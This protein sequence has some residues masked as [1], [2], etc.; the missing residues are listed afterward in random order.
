MSGIPRLIVDRQSPTLKETL[1]Q[2]VSDA[3]KDDIMAPVTVVGPTRYANL[4]LRHE[5]GRSGFIN[6]R[7]VVLPVLSE[8]LGAA[9]LARAGRKPLTSVLERVSLQEV[10]SQSTGP[11]SPVRDH[12]STLASVRASFRELRSCR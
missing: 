9:S 12:P 5:L 4:N 3:K 8:M 7:F 2:L 11:L 10:L 6:V 1:W